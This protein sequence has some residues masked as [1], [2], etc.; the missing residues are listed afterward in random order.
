MKIKSCQSQGVSPEKLMSVQQELRRTKQETEDVKDNIIE[1]VA[2]KSHKGPGSSGWNGWQSVVMETEYDRVWVDKADENSQSLETY[3]IM[4]K[5]TESEREAKDQIT[6][7][8]NKYAHNGG[9]RYREPSENLSKIESVESKVETEMSSLKMYL[10]KAICW[11][12]DKFGDDA[13][14]SISD[15]AKKALA[16]ATQLLERI[17]RIEQVILDLRNTQNQAPDAKEGA[18]SQRRA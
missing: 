16:E 14:K 7:Q 10:A 6:E 17:R 5:M 2:V 18:S 11:N 1:L 4:R 13:E 3:D 15:N 8:A 9:R 12:H